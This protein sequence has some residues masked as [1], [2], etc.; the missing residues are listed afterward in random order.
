MPL[1]TDEQVM[2]RDMARSWARKN[3]PVSAL[4]AMRDR[5]DERGFDPRTLASIAEMGWT[6]TVIPEAYG[7]SDVGY[8]SMGVVLEELGR[9]LIAAPLIGSAVGA[10]SA[11]KEGGGAAQQGRWLPGI[12][13]GS[14]VAALAVDETDRYAPGRI[15]LAARANGAGYVLDGTKIVVH[16]GLAADVLVVAARTAGEPTDAEGVTLFLVPTDGPGITRRRRH[17]LDARGYADVTF[18]DAPVAPDA[19]I[20]EPGRSRALL[21]RVLDRATA[22]AAAEALGLAQQAFEITIDYLK[23]RVQFGQVIGTFQALQHRAARMYTDIQLAR[24]CLD[25]ALHALDTGAPN[26]AAQVS[27]AK[28]TVNDLANTVTR[29][30]IQLH[31]G[32]GMTDAHDAG[33]FL[34]RARALEAAF[35]TSAYHR[36]R[37][38]RLHRI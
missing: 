27:L 18:E 4:R 20:G 13:D 33:F 35:G 38:A 22:A 9:T 19:V 37:Y 31:G 1:P 21:D 8:R 28:A 24:P 10:A 36:E 26:A 32:I 7:G 11:I 34:K 3:A 2:L 30:M 12:A 29:E 25:A 6:G 16:E 23:V 14:V 5:G 17:L 15:A